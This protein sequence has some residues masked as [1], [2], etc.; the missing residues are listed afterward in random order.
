[1][2]E[3]RCLIVGLDA[4]VT[5]SLARVL[6]ATPGVACAGIL[7]PAATVSGLAPAC[8]AVLLCD[9][10]G[11]T[12][13]ELAA[14][15][16]SA[17]PHVPVLLMMGEA[18]IAEYQAAL[19]VGARGVLTLPPDPEHLTALIANAAGGREHQQPQTAGRAIAVCASKGGTGCSLL[20]A[21]LAQAAAG[22][23][24]DLAAGYDNAAERLGCLPG[25]TLDDASRLDGGLGAEALR[26]LSSTHPD[27]WRLVARP[28]DPA[29]IS[30]E[31][32]R[33][34]VRE[35]RAVAPLTAFDLGIAASEPAAAVAVSCDRALLVTTPDGRAVGCAARAAAWLEQRG[36]PSGSLGLVV[37]RW[38]RGGDLSL[39]GIE[40][41]VGLPILA[42][43]REGAMRHEELLAALIARYRDRVRR[44]VLEHG[45]SGADPRAAV[46]ARTRELLRHELSLAPADV[47]RLVDAM[48][49]DALGAGPLEALM[50]DPEVTEVIAN[51][52]FDV[53]VERR[54]VLQRERV[55]FEDDAHLRHVIER[56]VAAVGRRVDES[57]PMVDAR[58]PDGSRVNAV[59][60]PVAVDGPLL[61]IRRFTA[62][63]LSID[64]LTALGSITAGQAALLAAAVAG[65]L[66]IVVSG[67]TGTGKTTLLNAMAAFIG[68]EER[69][70]TVED[71][72]ELRLSQTHV[73]RL[74]SR[75]PNVQG[76]GAIDLRALVRNALR[77]RPDRI[78]VGEVRGPEALD[79]LQA[80][81]TGHDGSL[82][83]VHASS[84]ADALR[85]IE[86]MVLMAGLELPHEIVREQVAAAVDVIVHVARSPDGH[87]LLRSIE[88]HDRS[89]ET[90]QR[91]ALDD[92]LVAAMRLRRCGA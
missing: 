12:A 83:T 57:S 76:A 42:A 20:A 60:P 51:G 71:T 54:G 55:R 59:L 79:M 85:R 31:L 75:P 63:G 17:L 2:T 19:A 48:L 90:W 26:A 87:R 8:D 32:G 9:G 15:V 69:I 3:R 38:R 33:A 91:R 23:L 30:P 11:A 37:N 14:A 16:I 40:R 50:R 6:S 66:N 24:V 74:E 39:R 78:V 7:E 77:M 72:A 81:N 47:D 43:V 89:G 64:Q 49:D 46:A 45:S 58:L 84:P 70:V 73:A 61:T 10:G 65:R 53:Y 36:M 86:I 82:T 22:M 68:R 34:L 52:P 27:G 44:Q 28:A 25:R 1:M 67:G 92:E 18:D 29:G 4:A 56:I 41:A 35:S 88:G 80:M 21:G 13:V 5:A 62:T